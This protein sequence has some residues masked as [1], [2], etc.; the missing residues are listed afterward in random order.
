[1]RVMIRSKV[2]KRMI[3]IAKLNPESPKEISERFNISL[4][5]V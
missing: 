4:A 2:F 3:E 5:I 1:M